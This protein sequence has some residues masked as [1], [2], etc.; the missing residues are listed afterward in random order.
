MNQILQLNILYISCPL[1]CFEGVYNKVDNIHLELG[2]KITN[3]RDKI[4]F[5]DKMIRV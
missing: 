1:I 4:H 2:D 5:L 3:Y